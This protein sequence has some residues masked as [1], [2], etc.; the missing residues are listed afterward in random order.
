MADYLLG[1][2]GQSTMA[3]ELWQCWASRA[4]V[5]THTIHKC[6]V[7]NCFNAHTTTEHI[8][9]L[10]IASSTY[11]HLESDM[12]T[13]TCAYMY[14]LKHS[15]EKSHL[16]FLSISTAIWSYLRVTL[17]ASALPHTHK[18]MPLLHMW[19]WHIP[20]YVWLLVPLS[21]IEFLTPM[22][23]NLEHISHQTHI[24]VY[25]QTLCS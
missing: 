21:V 20:I 24:H 25:A 18:S 19:V 8:W 3:S 2:E 1:V 10:F 9:R 12:H 22:T 4:S 6:K 11:G 5:I 16:C 14:K 7:R 17:K 23:Y 13:C 15:T